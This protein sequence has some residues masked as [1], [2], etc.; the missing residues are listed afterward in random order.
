MLQYQ[1][2]IG[3]R[4]IGISATGAKIAS[5]ILNHYNENLSR[6]IKGDSNAKNKLKFPEFARY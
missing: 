5:M 6:F 1:N 2:S 3:K 4:A